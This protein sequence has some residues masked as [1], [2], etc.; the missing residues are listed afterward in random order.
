MFRIEMVVR[1]VNQYGDVVD[2]RGVPAMHPSDHTI[3]QAYPQVFRNANE[4]HEEMKEGWKKLSHE[5]AL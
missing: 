5:P 1:V 3:R 2:A 4:A